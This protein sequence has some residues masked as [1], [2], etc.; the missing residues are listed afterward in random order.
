MRTKIL[1]STLCLL[2]FTLLSFKSTVKTPK[3][4][5]A[6]AGLSERQAAAHLLSRFTFGAKPGQ[7]DEVLTKGLDNWF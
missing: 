5:Y 7:I 2:A 6:Q 3:M 4:P 1:K